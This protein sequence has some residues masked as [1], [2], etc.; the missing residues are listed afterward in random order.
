MFWLIYI[1][2]GVV[3]FMMCGISYSLSEDQ[4]DKQFFARCAFL[5]ILW[6]IAIIFFAIV[7]IYGIMYELRNMVKDANFSEWFSKLHRSSKG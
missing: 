6:P 1:V 7:S 2:V 4:S 3:S 5:S